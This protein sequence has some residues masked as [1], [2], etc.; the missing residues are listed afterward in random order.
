LKGFFLKS[1]WANFLKQNNWNCFYSESNLGTIFRL[2]FDKT[3]FFC[4]FFHASFKMTLKINQER[5]KRRLFKCL[6]IVGHRITQRSYASADRRKFNKEKIN[7][8]RQ[9]GGYASFQDTVLERQI[10]TLYVI[11]G[12]LKEQNLDSVLSNKKTLIS[13]YDGRNDNV[14]VN[15]KAQLKELLD[16]HASYHKCEAK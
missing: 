4:Q 9:G 16:C 5:R 14:H 7:L 12:E 3:G 13:Q 2:V 15:I 1:E 11:V 8:D 6:K 10:F